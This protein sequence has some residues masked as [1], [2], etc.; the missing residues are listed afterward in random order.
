MALGRRAVLGS[1]IGMPFVAQATNMAVTHTA[2]IMATGEPGGGFAAYGQAWGQAAQKATR[3]AISYR[4]S[5]GS[6]ANVLLVEQAAAQLG[7]TVLAVA[8]QAWTGHGH[9]TGGVQLR[10]F[11]ALFPV[12]GASL[13]IFAPADS[14]LHRLRD[15]AGKRIGIGPAGG[16]GAVLAPQ[17][18]HAAG[19]PP[20]VAVNGL[21]GEQIALLRHGHIDACAF[22]GA[23][24]L[25][26]IHQA[27]ANGGF[28]LIGFDR[29][30]IGAVRKAIPGLD[31]TVIPHPALP[32]LSAA[33]ATV[34]S[35]AIAIGRADLPDPLARA[36]TDAALTH[37]AALLSKLPG[38]SAP[39]IGTGW[40]DGAVP[41]AIHP[42]A[43]TALRHHGLAVPA[44]LIRS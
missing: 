35:S 39:P 25:P 21:Y 19:A 22:F 41:I 27:A 18:L 12:F 28:N 1:M 43:A 15:L 6:A 33:V 2:I 31:A 34:G 29:D 32:A 4:A 11:R 26:A 8:N 14:G 16:A 7:L 3:I 20:R 5:G 40:I 10:G 23:T 36:V 24:P 13:Q 37:H 42:G 44:G 9:W 38:I 30:E 17:A